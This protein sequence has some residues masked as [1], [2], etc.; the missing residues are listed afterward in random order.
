MHPAP[1]G[2]RESSSPSPFA[3]GG[4]ER[5]WLIIDAKGKTVAELDDPHPAHWIVDLWNATHQPPA[6]GATATPK[7]ERETPPQRRDRT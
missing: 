6:E 3:P 4:R 2:V 1:W 7:D 5:V